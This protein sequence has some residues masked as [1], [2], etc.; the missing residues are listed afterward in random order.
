MLQLPRASIRIVQFD[1]ARVASRIHARI[2]VDAPPRP[3]PARQTERKPSERRS[4]GAGDPGSSS[5]RLVELTIRRP[6]DRR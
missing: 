2:H 3:P 4:R 5:R 6:A 1:L